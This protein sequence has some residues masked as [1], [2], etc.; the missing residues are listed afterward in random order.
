MPE[1]GA[2]SVDS[3]VT[4]HKVPALFFSFLF[5]FSFFFSASPDGDHYLEADLR[6]GTYG[7]TAE[8]FSPVMTSSMTSCLHFR[9]RVRPAATLSVCTLSV[10]NGN[11]FLDCSRWS[12]SSSGG[13]E[14]G[15]GEDRWATGQASLPPA[16]YPYAVVFRLRRGVVG[17][18]ASID[19][20]T[21]TDGSCSWIW[22]WWWWWWLGAR[23]SGSDSGLTK[24]T[25][26]SYRVEGAVPCLW[27]G[28]N[29]LK[30]TLR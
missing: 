14:G 1:S 9:F 21:K 5:F 16:A 27:T 6:E 8:L 4:I 20:V 10:V 12:R 24:S 26:C 3:D 2:R 17:G 19:D 13:G 23:C 15:E 11:R 30:A 7:D 25:L 28:R 18:V 22:W 29:G